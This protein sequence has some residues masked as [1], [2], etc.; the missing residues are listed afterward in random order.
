MGNLKI[1]SYKKIKQSFLASINTIDET[2][3]NMTEPYEI[4][5]EQSSFF[6]LI[7]KEV[8]KNVNLPMGFNH[9]VELVTG[10]EWID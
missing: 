6:N 7:K 9:S 8:V 5:L 10:R 4:I 2:T 3:G 1:K